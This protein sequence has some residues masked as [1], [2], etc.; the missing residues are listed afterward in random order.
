MIRISKKTQL[1]PEA[2]MEKA[3]QYFSKELGMKLAD[4]SACCA[5]FEGTGG[6]VKISFAVND[7][8]DVEIESREWENQA[9]EFLS[10]F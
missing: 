10:R 4:L 3:V 6:H 8:T 2:I 9:K 5:Y 7:N 1:K